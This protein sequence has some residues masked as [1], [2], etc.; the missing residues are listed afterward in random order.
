MSGFTGIL[1]GGGTFVPAGGA[2]D[3]TLV[4]VAVA[5]RVTFNDDGTV[6]RRDSSGASVAYS[7][8]GAPTPFSG[9][10]S[11]FWINFTLVGGGAGAVTGTTG[12]WLSL[13]AGQ[14]IGVV[15]AAGGAVT[16]RA[17]TYEIASDAA[18][19]TVVASGTVDVENDRS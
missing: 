12:S 2:Y 19:L 17:F 18:G 10:G 7:T 11:L 5:P 4:T 9:A 3:N 6:Y 16:V 8:W 13:A 1:M 14:F 15:S